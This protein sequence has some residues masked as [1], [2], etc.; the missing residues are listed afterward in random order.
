MKEW[1]DMTT[2][3]RTAARG[4]DLPAEKRIIMERCRERV[5]E[6][7]QGYPKAKAKAGK[8]T[9]GN[10]LVNAPEVTNNNANIRRIRGR[11]AEMEKRQTE[12]APEG[13]AFGGGTVEVD[14]DD[15]RLRVLF[16]DVPDAD[17]RAELKSNGFKWSPKHKAW[18]RQLTGNALYAAKRI[19]GITPI[20]VENLP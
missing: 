14:T 12:P 5:Y 7:L 15:N 9:W 3:E 4:D 10:C 11:I 19:K 16:D 1:C 8:V 6:L 17:L 20:K 2:E 13:W 18:Q